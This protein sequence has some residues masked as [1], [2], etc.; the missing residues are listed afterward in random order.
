M[1]ISTLDDESYSGLPMTKQTFNTIH[2]ISDYFHSVPHTHH[3][4]HDISSVLTFSIGS[5]TRLSVFSVLTSMHPALS[6]IVRYP[7]F[8]TPFAH[9]PQYDEISFT[10]RQAYVRAGVAS[11]R[12]REPE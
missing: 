1:M 10:N 12:R 9:S 4:M 5:Y 2:A 8:P 3:K 7:L 6:E 11:R